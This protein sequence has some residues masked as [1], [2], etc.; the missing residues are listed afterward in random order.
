VQ[1]GICSSDVFILWLMFYGDPSPFSPGDLGGL[2]DLDLE[3]LLEGG[4]RLLER[5][6]DLEAAFFLWG[7]RDLERL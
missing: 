1:S 3:A 4:V 6:R 5:E 2:L 7:E